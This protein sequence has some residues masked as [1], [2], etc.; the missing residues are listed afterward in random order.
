MSS[1]VS[2][3]CVARCLQEPLDIREALEEHGQHV[4]FNAE[5]TFYMLR[6]K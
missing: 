4:T 3:R 1:I 5:F 6:A 2:V